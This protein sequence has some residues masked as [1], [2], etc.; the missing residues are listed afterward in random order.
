[1][2]KETWIFILVAFLYVLQAV[3]GGM[4]ARKRGKSFWFWFAV[5]FMIVSPIGFIAMLLYTRDDN[6]MTP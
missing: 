6:P 3:V 1:M 5:T 4:I 2:D